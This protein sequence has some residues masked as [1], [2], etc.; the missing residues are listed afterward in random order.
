MPVLRDRRRHPSTRR[1][2]PRL[3]QATK[4]VRYGVPGES[5]GANG[6]PAAD[7]NSVE[8]FARLNKPLRIDPRE[9]APKLS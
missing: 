9:S 1:A 3:S 7:L 5:A 6:E 4:A 2:F 8:V